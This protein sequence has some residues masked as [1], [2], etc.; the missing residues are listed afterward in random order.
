[1][2]SAAALPDITTT[3]TADQHI[4]HNG[5]EYTTIKE[6]LAYILIPAEASKIPQTAPRGENQPQ[7]VFYNPIQQF[8]RDLTVLA[9]KSYG[10]DVIARKQVALEKDRDKVSNKRREKKRKREE[11][12]GD[13]P[14]KAGKIDVSNN[15]SE[16]ITQS[17]TD[18]DAMVE[19]SDGCR[20]NESAEVLELNPKVPAVDVPDSG[21]TEQGNHGE[22]K[23]PKP[24]P[25][26]RTP[27]FTILDALSATGLRALR[28]VNEIPFTSSVTANDL[29]PAA[30]K[31]IKLNV[32]HNKLDE[33]IKAVTGNAMTHMYDLIGDNCKDDKGRNMPS[34]KYDVIDLDPYG[35]AAPFLDAA[36]QS[37]RDD[38]G[39]LCVTCTDAGVWA[40]NGYPEKAYSLYGGVPIKGMHSHEGGLRLILHA[41]ATSAARYGLA[42]EPLLS[43]SIDFYA[44]VFVKIHKSPA[45]VKFLAG[46]TMVVYSCDTGCGAW[47]TQMLAKNKLAQNKSGK[48]FFWKH[49]F[50]QAPLTSEKC[51]H[52]GMK[53]H[54]AGPM[55]AGPLHSPAFIK[56]ILDGLPSVSKDTYQT[57]ERIEGM[58]SMALEEILPLEEN[59]DSPISTT[60]TNRYDPAAV[61]HYPFLF[62]PSVLA[63]VVHC[64]TPHENALRGALRHLGYRVTRSHTKAGSIKTDAPW[65]VIWEVMREWVRQKAP[66]KEGAI[67]QGTAGWNIMGL[68]KTEGSKNA[69]QKSTS[70]GKETINGGDDQKGKLAIVFDEE[71]G[72]EKDAKKL[73]RFQLNPRENWGP[74]N[75][76]KGH[77]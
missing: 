26:A 41:I 10:E 45:E 25:K 53:T 17:A 36:V 55:Y 73:V 57:T 7:S 60:R 12:S 9:I 37:V 11:A 2:S 20:Q 42:I 65:E 35:T 50:E 24:A 29:L 14:R 63:K 31:T 28:Y 56:K 39:L 49:V 77:A 13:A 3:P 23:T 4:L 66:V 18:A 67:R 58:L 34:R 22:E 70:E 51:V 1:M 71:L 74:M 21:D 27:T 46:K 38:G 61:D 6:G 64:I 72:K 40:S 16:T 54:M 44:R 76:A 30:T 33:K 8:N 15:A 69:N 19:D 48:G 68:N 5:K 32:Q 62:I 52:C 75:R 59:P 47:T 43:L